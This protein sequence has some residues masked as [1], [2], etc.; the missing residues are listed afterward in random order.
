MNPSRITVRGLSFSHGTRL[1]LNALD[2]QLT[3]GCVTAVLG[4]NGAGKST[5]LSCVTGL[6]QPDAGG[7]LLDD[8]PLA[9]IAPAA[10]AR[11]IAFL[12]QTPEIAWAVDVATLVSLGRIPF[13]GQ[14][15][16]AQ[17]QA[18]VEQAMQLT[19]VAQ[20]RDRSV[21]TLSGGE[22]ARVLLARVLAGE[23]DWVLADE[24]FTGLDPVHQF[25]A[26][27]LLRAVATR[28]GGVV[29]TI[30]DLTLAARI[31]DR[32]IILNDGVIAA[33]GSPREALTPDIL[34]AVYKIDT[35]W[36]DDAATG[37]PTIVIHGRSQ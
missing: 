23:S 19:D 36:I 10:R 11:R 34:R 30:H 26:A 3:T 13:R 22:R 9:G 12:P 29:L 32:I 28:G 2:L 7:V 6:L 25:E 16:D 17:N 21:H 5:L 24:P 1:I 18:A 4:P 37:T 33:D 31:A 14:C 35:R 8:Q 15:S 20:W 27:E